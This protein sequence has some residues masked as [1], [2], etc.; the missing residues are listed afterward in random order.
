MDV[1]QLAPLAAALDAE[2]NKDVHIVISSPGGHVAAADLITTAIEGLK[3][4][5]TTVHCY[6]GGAAASAA[7]DV[8]MSCSKRHATERSR[9]LFH[10]PSFGGVGRVTIHD[11]A[12]ILEDLQRM[13]DSWLER[14]I[15]ELPMS[16]KDV[17]HHYKRET[18][19]MADELDDLLTDPEWITIH[20]TISFLAKIPGAVGIPVN[21]P[22]V[23]GALAAAG[24]DVVE[25]ACYVT[26]V[27]SGTVMYV[28]VLQVTDK[29]VL[30]DGYIGGLKIGEEVVP[31]SKLQALLSSGESKLDQGCEQFNQRAKQG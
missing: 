7:F 6:V 24:G 23:F 5:G 28:K 16:A 20:K 27:V 31:L 1:R 3:A 29:V 14:L 8:L 12:E 26:P 9:L 15:T 30:I 22:M 11:A 18:F 17:E 2:K 4:R 10:P 19:F 21:I 25:G 13:Y